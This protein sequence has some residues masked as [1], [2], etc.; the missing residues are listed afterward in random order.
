MIAPHSLA[1]CTNQVVPEVTMLKKTALNSAIALALSAL[2][3]A[4]VAGTEQ[5][6]P[7]TGGVLLDISHIDPLNKGNDEGN[8]QKSAIFGAEDVLPQDKTVPKKAPASTSITQVTPEKATKA[9]T[10]TSTTPIATEHSVAVEIPAVAIDPI[11]ADTK[12]EEFDASGG[13]SEPE[14]VTSKA[15]VAVATAGE[16]ASAALNTIV[17]VMRPQD[18]VQSLENDRFSLYFSDQVI[19][20]QLER[21]AS[22]FDLERART[23]LAFLHSEERDTVLQGGLSLDASFTTSFRLS[24]G[25]R[26]YIA[27]LNTENLDAFAAAMGAETAYRLPFKALPLELGASIYY[28]PDILTFGAGDQV[29]DWQVDVTLPVRP[30][31]SVFGGARFL[32][33]DTRPADREID[34]RVHL[35]VRW[36]F[37]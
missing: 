32:Q 17:E 4:A 18:T 26:A 29:I 20:A 36:D 22:R 9:Q 34:N 11:T 16:K 2:M 3:N 25:T 10:P 30:E 15:A 27:L 7:G 13:A 28:A 24:F 8:N 6:I 33:V 12:P 5:E 21:Q 23:H 14:P 31:F 1:G 35:G 19:F 37:L